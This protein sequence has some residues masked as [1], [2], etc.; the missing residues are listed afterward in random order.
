MIFSVTNEIRKSFLQSDQEAFNE[1]LPLEFTTPPDIVALAW[2]GKNG[3][4]F[5]ADSEAGSISSATIEV[6]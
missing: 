4:V 6:H 1:L 3:T 5:W 2:E